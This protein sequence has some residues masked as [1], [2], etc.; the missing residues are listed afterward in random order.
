MGPH[1]LEKCSKYQKPTTATPKTAGNWAQS[2]GKWFTMLFDESPTCATSHFAFFEQ[3]GGGHLLE[4]SSKPGPF[5]KNFAETGP[6][7]PK[8]PGQ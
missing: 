7:E 3:S 1:L 2:T 5:A 8:Q 4:I 6:G